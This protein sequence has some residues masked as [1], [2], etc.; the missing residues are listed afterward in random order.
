MLTTPIT[1]IFVFDPSTDFARFFSDC[2]DWGVT[3]PFLNPYLLQTPLLK[4]LLLRK[5]PEFCLNFPVYYDGMNTHI[6]NFV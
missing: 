2:R 5:T 1:G 4:S 3:L 6:L